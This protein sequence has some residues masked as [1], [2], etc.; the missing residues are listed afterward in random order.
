M[1][2][3]TVDEDLIDQAGQRMPALIIA[4]VGADNYLLDLPGE[5]FSAG[6]RILVGSGDV[7]VMNG[8]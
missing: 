2:V 3:V 1:Y 7:K 8:R 6:S 5:S 4:D